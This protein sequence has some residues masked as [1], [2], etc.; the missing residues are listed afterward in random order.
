MCNQQEFMLAVFAAAFRCHWIVGSVTLTM[1]ATNVLGM[2]T[3]QPVRVPT[4][5]D[6]ALL[7][8]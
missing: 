4:A 8:C 1:V 3:G 6:C 7:P 5:A 2:H